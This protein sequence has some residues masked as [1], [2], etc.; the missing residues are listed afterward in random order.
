MSASGP[1]PQTRTRLRHPHTSPYTLGEEIAHAITHGVGAALSIAG[2][3]LLVALAALR[4][5]DPWRVTSFSIYGATLF[6]LYLSSTLY[7]AIPS[8]RVKHFFKVLDHVSIYLLIAG[9]YTPFVL[10]TL[11]DTIGWIMFGLVWGLAVVG[12]LLKLFA[13]GRFRKLSLGIYLG[14]GWIC[15]FVFEDLM[16]VL[17]P[18]G[19]ALLLIGGLSYTFGVIFYVWERLPYNHAIWH[20]FVLGGSVTHFFAILHYVLPRAN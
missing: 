6:L 11:R 8:P 4:G 5:G 19:V 13:I 2:L 20:L 9:T 3:T 7:H 18:G 17:L 15:I 14:M 10:V 1:E 16:Q 12:I